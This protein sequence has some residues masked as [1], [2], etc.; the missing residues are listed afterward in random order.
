MSAGKGLTVTSDTRNSKV[1]A[2]IIASLT[3]GAAILLWL[4]P[5]RRGWSR[6]T[7]LIAERGRPIESA[8]IEFAP[9]D[10]PISPADYDCLV[11]PDGEHTWRPSGAQVRILV[12]GSGAERLATVQKRKLLS[13]LGSLNQ[14]LGLDLS[15]VSLLAGAGA[16][17][18]LDQPSEAGDLLE[19]LARKGII[20]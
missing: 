20:Q 14:S 15:R 7:T 11:F 12:V 4:E 13:V 8:L 19:L 3:V 2:L 17:T 5:P 1:V 6:S 9:L 18:D 10:R 16:S